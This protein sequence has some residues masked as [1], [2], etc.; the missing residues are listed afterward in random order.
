MTEADRTHIKQAKSFG[1]TAVMQPFV[2]GK[3]DLQAVRCALDSAG[4]AE[5]RLFAK[6]ENLAGIAHLAELIP[7]CD[8]IVIARGDLGNAVPLWELPAAQKR[9][10]AACREASR[11]FMVVTQMLDS[12]MHRQVPT[13]AEVS[14]IFNA[15]LDGA[16]SVMGP[17]KRP[18]ANTPSPRSGIFAKRC[19]KR[20]RIETPE[21]EKDTNSVSF[22]LHSFQ[23]RYP[24]RALTLKCSSSS[25][26][27]S[28]VI[29]LTSGRCAIFM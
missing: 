2:R 27:C 19:A 20:K 1:V 5:I 14:D 24:S 16:A 11:D 15:V 25:C 13:R 28:S 4:A 12:M 29:V 6:V 26:I 9:I 10:A 22:L 18:R 23:S 3:D 7:H 17:A 21:K 8:E